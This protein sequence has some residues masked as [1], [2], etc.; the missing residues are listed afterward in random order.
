M[1]AAETSTEP[2]EQVYQV[3]VTSD[4]DGYR[5]DLRRQADIVGE[6]WVSVS[7]GGWPSPVFDT[8]V[9]AHLRAV[10]DDEHQYRFGGQ[11]PPHRVEWFIDGARVD[12]DPKVEPPPAWAIR[13]A[14]GEGCQVEIDRRGVEGRVGMWPV[15]CRK[16][17]SG[18][19][20]CPEHIVER[21]RIMEGG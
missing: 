10:V 2:G 3:F 4:G 11:A 15:H 19:L 8:R 18:W 17:S 12:G 13:P 1:S 5:F 7:F 20:M 9:V 21:K 6:G 16:P 14:D